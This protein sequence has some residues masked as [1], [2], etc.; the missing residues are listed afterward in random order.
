M[1]AASVW[2]AADPSTALAAERDNPT[3]AF[4]LDQAVA[5]TSDAGAHRGPFGSIL[6]NANIA[7]HPRD[8][9]DEAPPGST[10]R[11]EELALES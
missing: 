9:V 6:R 4:Q 3:R 10:R 8:T 5:Q 11:T 1:L 2:D 7:S